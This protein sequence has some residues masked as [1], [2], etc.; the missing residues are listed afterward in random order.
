MRHWIARVARV[1]IAAV[2]LWLGGCSSGIVYSPAQPAEQ[3]DVPLGEQAKHL[4][5]QVR[6]VTM[7]PDFATA[8]GLGDDFGRGSGSLLAK[9]QVDKL[10]QEIQGSRQASIITAQQVTLDGGQAGHVAALNG[11]P[12]I[13][14]YRF[15][16]RSYEALTSSARHGI[17]VEL[18]AGSSDAPKT[19]ALTVRL[20]ISVLRN[21]P[22]LPA[23]NVPPEL[24]LM[25][26]H[27]ETDAQEMQTRAAVPDGSTLAVMQAAEIQ[28]RQV[29]VLVLACPVVE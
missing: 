24:N 17:E 6:V 3:S 19:I 20:R 29:N 15:T 14:G 11:Q 9:A 5:V 22:N 13:S 25:V 10:V 16:G 23:P 1:M 2:G 12:Y 7:E 4:A 26:Q 8:L 18:L 27:P 28:G 21:L